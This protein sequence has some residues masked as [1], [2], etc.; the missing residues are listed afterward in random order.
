M[1]KDI[2]KQ[3]RPESR[4]G[5]GPALCFLK[6]TKNERADVST[7]L[8]ARLVWTVTKSPRRE[9]AIKAWQARVMQAVVL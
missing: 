3:R 6:G 1:V 5:M 9:A 2:E 8:M 7:L 4:K